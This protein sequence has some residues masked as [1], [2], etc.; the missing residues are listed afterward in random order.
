MVFLHITRV[1][2]QPLV[3]QKS[4]RL[5]VFRKAPLPD[6]WTYSAPALQQQVLVLQLQTRRSPKTKVR[7]HLVERSS[8]L[9]RTHRHANPVAWKLFTDVGDYTTGYRM[10]KGG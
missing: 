4:W 8:L 6:W 2:A 9:A 3:E 7:V 5:R 10:V 1:A